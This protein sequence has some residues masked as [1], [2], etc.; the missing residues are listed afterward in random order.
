VV[1][2]LLQPATIARLRAIRRYVEQPGG[3]FP[4]PPTTDDLPVPLYG[5]TERQQLE[6]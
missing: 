5:Y 3:S 4:P 2:S 1:E 6:W